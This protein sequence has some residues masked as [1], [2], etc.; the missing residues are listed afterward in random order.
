MAKISEI[1]ALRVLKLVG[2][3]TACKN[4]Q[5]LRPFV[6]LDCKYYSGGSFFTVPLTAYFNADMLPTTSGSPYDF[7]QR[8]ALSSA[9]GAGSL[10]E[11]S[12]LGD[13]D[14]QDLRAFEFTDGI[15]KLAGMDP[16][17]AYPYV[18]I[19]ERKNFD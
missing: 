1:Y 3:N 2:D 13:L 9:I 7:F 6:I 11:I 15:V 5:N 12:W 17:T 16:A 4:Q 18:L 14:A 10:K 8:M 19:L